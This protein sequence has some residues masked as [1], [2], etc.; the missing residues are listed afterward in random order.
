MFLT[1]VPIAILNGIIL[2]GFIYK[3]NIKTIFYGG[4]AGLLTLFLFV[5]MSNPTL[6]AILRMGTWF[7]V[8]FYF[9]KN[10]ENLKINNTLKIFHIM[11][12]L[13]LKV[14][15]EVLIYIV[16]NNYYFHN[17]NRNN[18]ICVIISWLPFAIVSLNYNLFNYNLNMLDKLNKK[19]KFV[20]ILNNILGTIIFTIIYFFALL[21]KKGV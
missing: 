17:L 12:F 3:F 10:D 11:F 14:L 9:I 4:F 13:S 7:F 19:I 8:I 1:D 20:R 16:Q 18:F 2:L 21:F 6:A 5:N 15:F